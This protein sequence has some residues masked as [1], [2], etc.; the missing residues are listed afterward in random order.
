MFYL[1]YKNLKE[2]LF[3]LGKL[4]EIYLIIFIDTQHLHYTYLDFQN[5]FNKL[6]LIQAKTNKRA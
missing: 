4:E 6:S 1:T 2:R 5:I 3:C